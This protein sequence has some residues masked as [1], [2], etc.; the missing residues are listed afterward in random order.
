MIEAVGENNFK[1]YSKKIYDTHEKFNLL[2]FRGKTKFTCDHACNGVRAELE[3]LGWPDL[4]GA[5]TIC[6]SHNQFNFQS[7]EDDNHNDVANS[8]DQSSKLWF[9]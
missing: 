9:R 2:E 7:N 1:T 5:F 8:D 4:S 3:N 6:N